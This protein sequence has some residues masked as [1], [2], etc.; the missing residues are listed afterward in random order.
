MG[1]DDRHAA[2]LERIV[3]ACTNTGKIPGWL[4]GPRSQARAEQKLDFS[5]GGDAGFM[6]AG[7]RAG[8]QTLGLT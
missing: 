4:P 2:P 6:L 1:N 8:L 5:A 3:Q 7:A